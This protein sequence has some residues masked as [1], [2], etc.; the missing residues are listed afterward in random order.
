M[1]ESAFQMR[2]KV[3][4]RD[5]TCG[6]SHP[7]GLFVF[8]LCD[9]DKVSRGEQDFVKVKEGRQQHLCGCQGY[10]RTASFSSNSL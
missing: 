10:R 7:V 5:S 8:L 3:V 2:G 4:V 9:A 6:G 1:E